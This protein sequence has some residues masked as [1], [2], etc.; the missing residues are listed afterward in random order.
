MS[1]RVALIR[2]AG[3]ILVISLSFGVSPQLAAT[4]D[5][6]RS[7][8]HA[9]ISIAIGNEG[10]VSDGNRLARHLYS[11]APDAGFGSA[12]FML[13]LSSFHGDTHSLAAPRKLYRLNLVFLI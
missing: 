6:S 1:Y 5:L 11:R 12:T 7:Q 8:S 13:A 4:K 10:D 3:L 9:A 2:A